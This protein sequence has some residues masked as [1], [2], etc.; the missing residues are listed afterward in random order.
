MTA[1]SF[2]R[3]NQRL[4]ERAKA[5][6]VLEWD[7]LLNLIHAL[8]LALPLVLLSGE[9]VVR[10]IGIFYGAGYLFLM[11]IPTA[12]YVLMALDAFRVLRRRL[13]LFMPLLIAIGKRA[14]KNPTPKKHPV[15]SFIL[16]LG[17]TGN[18]LASLT[19]E[20]WILAFRFNPDAVKNLDEAA[21][22]IARD[23][24]VDKDG[25]SGQLV[26]AEVRT[27]PHRTVR[28]ELVTC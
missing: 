23:L 27:I 11:L 12:I 26:A 18:P 21:D 10:A 1:S 19:R 15:L 2:A 4:A 3:D 7:S 13:P 5:L 22:R 28:L 25:I 9:G 20:I 24:D 16:G 17:I 6:A 8:L 14:K